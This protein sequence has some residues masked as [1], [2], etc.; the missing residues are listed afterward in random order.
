MKKDL[1]DEGLPRRKATLEA[2]YVEKNLAAADAFTRPFQ[3]AMT[4]WC[5][6]FGWGDEALD[7]QTRSLMNL[8]II[9]GLGKMHEWETHCR[10]ALNNGVSMEEIRAAIHVVGIYCGVPQALELSCRQQGS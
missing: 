7:A 2:E 10:G 3:E 8:A 4:A 5:W 6:G 1:F 9:G